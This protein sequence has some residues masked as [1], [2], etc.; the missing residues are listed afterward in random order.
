[1]F[2]A[3]S[4]HIEEVIRPALQA[5]RIVLCDRFT[6]STVAYQGYGRGIPL[7]AIRALERLLCHDVRPDLTLLLDIDPET[8]A[9]RTGSRNRAAQQAD[10]RFEGES[11][12]FFRRVR[13]GYLEIAQREPNRVRIID[14]SGG[15]AEVH[16]DVQR[17]VDAFL[18]HTLAH[19]KG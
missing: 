17:A 11:L 6:D 18:K 15:I 19:L 12:D 1:M 10:T 9:E 4:Q 7:D 14:N 8:A 3:R 2:A 5:G 13:Q 16:D